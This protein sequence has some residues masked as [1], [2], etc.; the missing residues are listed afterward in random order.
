MSLPEEYHSP[1][2]YSY[3]RNEQFTDNENRRGDQLAKCFGVDYAARR[4]PDARFIAANL[5]RVS[6]LSNRY[7]LSPEAKELFDTILMSGVHKQTVLRWLR[8]YEGFTGS[9]VTNIT[10]NNIAAVQEEERQ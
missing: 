6:Q 8:D 5:T 10:T 9:I 7:T 1:L 2:Y 3:R 4:K